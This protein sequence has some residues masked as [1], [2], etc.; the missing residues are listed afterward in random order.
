MD[1]ALCFVAIGK[2]VLLDDFVVSVGLVVVVCD[3]VVEDA[4][5]VDDVL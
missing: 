5:F 2:R 4:V 3:A 1:V